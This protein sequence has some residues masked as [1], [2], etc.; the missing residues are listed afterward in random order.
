MSSLSQVGQAR[1]HVPPPSTTPV[2]EHADLAEAV[3]ELLSE[4]RQ[5]KQALAGYAVMETTL[6]GFMDKISGIS[7]TPPVAVVAKAEEVKTALAAGRI[8]GEARAAA[9]ELAS[10]LNLDQLALLAEFDGDQDAVI[11]ILEALRTRVHRRVR[12]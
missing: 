8:S 1:G 6:K 9:G 3:A 5:I 10:Q 2:V 11:K 12:R 7:R 4:I